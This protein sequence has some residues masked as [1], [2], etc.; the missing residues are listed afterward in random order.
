MLAR[1]SLLG[2]A[3]VTVIMPMA[4]AGAQNVWKT[5]RNERFGTSIEYP[6][7]RFHALPPPENGDGLR[8]EASDGAEF[9][10]SAIRN[11]LE[12]TFAEIQESYLQR[13][14]Q[15]KDITYRTKGK[16]WFVYSGTRGDMIF[17]ERHL[18]SHRN[19]LINTFEITYPASLKH[20]YDPIA[21][22]MSRTL[23]AH[24]GWHTGP[25]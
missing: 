22:R 17:Y 10:V 5:Y 15:P 16:N 13:D 12:E 25:L 20:I 7:D 23:R 19:E 2:L 4:P 11:A 3:I 9:V 14:G 6:A 8:F 1:R 24:V 21:A 18:V